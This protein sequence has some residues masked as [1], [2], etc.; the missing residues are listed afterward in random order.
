MPMRCQRRFG[1]LKCSWC[2]IA[3]SYITLGVHVNM[4]ILW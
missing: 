1:K 3:S 2:W 4:L